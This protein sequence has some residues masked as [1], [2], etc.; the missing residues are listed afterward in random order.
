MNE[1]RQTRASPSSPD[2]ADSSLPTITIQPP[3][4]T[5]LPTPPTATSQPI[6]AF[7][8]NPSSAPTPLATE[9][10]QA[11]P[12]APEETP[13]EDTSQVED[14]SVDYNE[15]HWVPIK[16][17]NNVRIGGEQF[18]QVLCKGF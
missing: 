15:Y 8:E 18:Q 17:V 9:D 13:A 3:A 5:S 16:T 11:I 10:T 1:Q 14:Q 6:Y 12:P 2:H 7:D 4:A